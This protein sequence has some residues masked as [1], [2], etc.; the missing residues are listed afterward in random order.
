MIKTIDEYLN[1]YCDTISPRDFYRS[2]FPEGSLEQ[3]G[4]YEK[5]KYNAIAI[6][7]PRAKDNKK[8]HRYTITDDLEGIDTLCQSDLFCLMSPITYAGKSRKSINARFMYALAIDLDGIKMKNVNGSPIGMANL[9]YQFDGHG[10][11]N[12]LPLPTYLVSSGTGLHI[13]YVFE[14]PIPL[15]ENIVEQ[16]AILKNRLTWMLWT[17][18]VSD[19][20]DKVQYESLFQGFRVPGTITKKA[21]RAQAYIVDQGKKVTIEYLNQFVPE[22]YQVKSFTYKSNLTLSKAKEKYP[23]WYEKRIV[24]K[25]K[26][27]HWICKRDLYD[28]WKRR[29]LSGAEAGHRYWCVMT[30]ATYAVKCN[31]PRE[32]LEKDALDLL[33]FLESKTT[34]QDNHF[35]EDD[36]LAALDAYDDSYITYP[37]DTISHRTGIPIEKNKRNYQKQKDHLEEARA[38]RDIRM[39]RQGRKWD[40]NNGRKPKKDIV[41]QWRKNHPDGKKIDCERDTG[42]SRP[43]VLKWWDGDSDVVVKPTPQKKPKMT[44]EQLIQMFIADMMQGLPTDEITNKVINAVDPNSSAE[45]RARVRDLIESTKKSM[46]NILALTKK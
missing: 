18:G 35:T 19:L 45:E 26:K 42:L 25:K 6:A 16:L 23:E 17:Q 10:P 40:D 22:E 36:I 33:D 1:T 30:L 38:I 9:F 21:T 20:K 14:Q 43:T 31:I 11:S 7:L 39:H 41:Q 12:Y 2:I 13:Y 32:E 29:I 27:G 5:G 8:V 37:I 4:I 46:E 15:F 3:K 34:E 44:D 24:Q 28:W